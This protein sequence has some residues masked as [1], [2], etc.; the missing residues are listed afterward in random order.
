[1]LKEIEI[2]EVSDLKSSVYWL[3]GVAGCGKSTIA[4]TVAERSAAHGRLGAS[5]FCS[6]DYPNRRD[7]R[8]IFPTLARDLAHGHPNYKTA[9]AQIIRSDPDVEHD[10]LAVQFERLIVQPLKSTGLS[11]TI[12]VDALDECKDKEPVSAFLSVLAKHIDEI[13]NVKFFITG[14]PE[15][16]IRSG[17]AIPS[18]R[19]KELSLH[20]VES[21][22][23][24]LDIESFVRA[25]LEAISI[26]HRVNSSVS[27]SWPSGG[28]IAAV[29]RKASGLFIIASI[30]VGFVDDPRELPQDRLKLMISR[31]DST[32]YEGKAKIDGT[33]EQVLVASFS[34]VSKDN[35]K[36]IQ[37]LQLVLASIVLAFHPLSRASL[38]RI[39]GM[40]SER[41]WMILRSLH[42][43]LIV[44]DSDSKPIRICHKSFADFLT[45]R[46]RCSDER[47]YI[48]SPAHHSQ[49][50]ILCLELMKST[51]TKNICLLPPYRMNKD[52][53]DLDAR[54]DKYIGHALAYGCGY[55]A[56]HIEMSIGASYDMR[57]VIELVDQFF[58]NHFLSW[59]EVLSIEAN[60]SAAIYSIRGVRSLLND[61]KRLWPKDPKRSRLD[62]VLKRWR[63]NKV[64]ILTF[65]TFCF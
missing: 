44:P 42:S 29:T 43:V 45:D 7:L 1:V 63:S 59:L 32:V 20:D 58:K 37:Q 13:P 48:D 54:R 51:L 55:W 27:G 30:I 15:D 50:G 57:M 56:K 34:D 5:F 23:V 16:H 35:S 4:Q 25:E 52:I 22:A 41:I 31:L 14:R 19:T 47:F 46:Q 49:L 39:L 18:L 38:A 36:F 53:S 12:V 62:N 26:R 65:G 60:L 33:Y 24:D 40:S 3:K 8:L 21:S 61:V 28:D 9:L 2:W 6:R 17:F 10:T 64:S 11:L